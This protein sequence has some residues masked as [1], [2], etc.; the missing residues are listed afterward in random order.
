MLESAIL[1]EFNLCSLEPIEN[2]EPPAN[3]VETH[4]LPPVELRNEAASRDGITSKYRFSPPVDGD[5]RDHSGMF[6]FLDEIA[7]K[8]RGCAECIHIEKGWFGIDL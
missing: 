6:Q 3:E 8:S 2:F 5:G 1:F 4:I 7:V